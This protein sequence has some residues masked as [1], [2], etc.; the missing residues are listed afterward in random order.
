MSDWTTQ[1][2][3][4]WPKR[5]LFPVIAGVIDVVSLVA[6]LVGLWIATSVAVHL[7][8]SLL[9]AVVVGLVVFPGVPLL[10]EIWH[11]IDRR[12]Y[13][14]TEDDHPPPRVRI[15]RSALRVNAALLVVALIVFPRVVFTAITT[16]GDWMM[17]GARGP[18]RDA[19]LAVADRADF[20]YAE[21]NPFDAFD[22]S[23]KVE[24]VDVGWDRTR[25][26][27]GAAGVEPGGEIWDVGTPAE[28]GPGPG[29][30]PGP[31]S[32]SGS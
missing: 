6:G 20:L 13:G 9:W 16:R 15:L 22:D 1:D 8:V 19:L 3:D 26:R 10:L 2:Y 14:E 27:S 23:V 21:D 31:E 18:W 4:A 30:G 5:V 11:R 12:R 17:E 7:N 24:P 32:E 28:P 25:V 29:S